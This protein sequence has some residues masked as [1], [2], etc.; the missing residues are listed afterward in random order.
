MLKNLI[1]RYFSGKDKTAKTEATQVPF[2]KDTAA[3]E[4]IDE[5]STSDELQTKLMEVTRTL[6]TLQLA[7]KQFRTPATKVIGTLR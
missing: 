3:E 1:H 2:S 4:P 7:V 5:M 6:Q